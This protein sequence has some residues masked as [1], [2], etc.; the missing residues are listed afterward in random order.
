MLSME[1]IAVITPLSPLVVYQKDIASELEVHTK[2]VSRALSRAPVPRGKR[3]HRGYKLDPY[4]DKINQLLNNGGWNAMV[5][6]QKIPG[7]FLQG[8]DNDPESILGSKSARRP[9]TAV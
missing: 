6:L 5:I 4:K 3:N 1:D 7:S 9:G 8:R 2:T